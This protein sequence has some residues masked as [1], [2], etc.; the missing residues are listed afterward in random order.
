MISLGKR[1]LLLISLA[2]VAGAAFWN[3]GLPTATAECCP[4]KEVQGIIIVPIYEFSL[5]VGGQGSGTVNI[6]PPGISTTQS[7][8]RDYDG[9]ETVSLTASAASG[10][11]FAGWSGDCSG[12]GHCSVVMDADRSVAAIFNKDASVEG[13]CSL[14][15]S[16]TSVGTG[17]SLSLTIEASHPDGIYQLRYHNG[18]DWMGKY[19]C[20]DQQNCAG[21]WDI[22]HSQPGTYHYTGGFYTPRGTWLF[23]WQSEW[24][25]CSENIAVTVTDTPDPAQQYTLSGTIIGT[26]LV[27]V[28]PPHTD[29]DASF[30]QSYNSGTSVTL[31]AID[32]HAI[33]PE[34]WKFAG[35]SGACSGTSYT[36]TVDMTQNRSVTATFT[37][38]TEPPIERKC[39]LS[40][41]PIKVNKGETFEVRAEIDDPDGIGF[42]YL[43]ENGTYLEDALNCLGDQY[44]GATWSIIQSQAGNYTYRSGYYTGK[45]GQTGDKVW[46][47]CPG[48]VTVTVEEEVPGL[49][50]RTLSLNVAGD[51]SG[52]VKLTPPG[53]ETTI[54]ISRKYDHGVTVTLQASA[55][56][57]STFAGWSGACS[58]TGSCTIKMDQNRSVTATFDKDEST[59]EKTLS[60]SKSGTGSGTVTSSPSG[61]NCGTICSTTFNH[62][63]SVSLTATPNSGSS[64]AGWSGA[65]SGTGL[66]CTVT[67]TADR[68][69]T[70]TFDAEDAP[71]E[72]ILN[73]VSKLDGQEVAG[74]KISRVSGNVKAGTTNY[75]VVNQ[76]TII[77]VLRAPETS[78]EASFSHWSEC[79][80]SLGRECKVVVGETTIDGLPI[81]TESELTVTAHY[82]TESAIEAGC[83]LTIEPKVV[84]KK[85]TF[86]LTAEAQH[87]DGIT[88]AFYHERGTKDGW[89]DRSYC[90]DQKNCTIVWP[91]TQSNSGTYEYAVGFYTPTGEWFE[92]PQTA[93]VAVRGNFN[94]TVRSSIDGTLQEGVDIS[95]I[96]GKWFTGGIT[97]Y[98]ISDWA[99]FKTTLNAPRTYQGNEFD[100]WEGCTI[101]IGRWCTA[102]VG[103]W[104]YSASKTITAHYTP[105]EP[106]C[107][108][109]APKRIEAGRTFQIRMKIRHPEGVDYARYRETGGTWSDAFDCGDDYECTAYWN[110]SRDQLKTYKFE[111]EFYSVNGEQFSCGQTIQV[112]VQEREP[113]VPGP[114]PQPDECQEG[115]VC[116]VV[117]IGGGADHYMEECRNGQWV[118]TGEPCVLPHPECK[119]EE[120][121]CFNG[122]VWLCSSG[123]WVKT[124][125]S[126]SP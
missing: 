102:Q 18:Q 52:T 97:E 56:T 89:R 107:S 17:E 77:G 65:C 43:R 11:T 100:H 116:C 2:I 79:Q 34:E 39:V 115:E 26:G 125:E 28:N 119:E 108:L 68:L 84:D 124:D 76:E 40:A 114:E 112:T 78:G 85:E 13:G 74:V 111:G 98:L 82:A 29:Y 54:S 81:K 117:I 60:V 21:T 75:S 15:V 113:E 46:V 12:T 36:C 95:R 109:S 31:T 120:V 62:G 55:Y 6:N 83:K 24:I 61:I 1:S 20:Y 71:G 3:I 88:Y 106:S 38:S 72:Y 8:T 122:S 66:S 22:T 70:A 101:S 93:Q 86:L 50:Q 35:W 59:E 7:I 47:A 30:S 87:P 63:T 19:E 41:T 27:K 45:S 123:Y 23:G 67:M 49:E 37:K 25:S 121:S 104:P 42:V 48:Q 9:G 33:I 103:L 53:V 110:L 51:G 5:T 94:V 4:R 118:N 126:C 73:V 92:C 69:A 64:F 57:G 90:H 44:C 80:S 96:S 32:K 99:P 14:S 58:G 105:I 91:L 10:S 16:K